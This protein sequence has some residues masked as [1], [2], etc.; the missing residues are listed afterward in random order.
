MSQKRFI[1]IH[2]FIQQ[3][4]ERVKITK[5]RKEDGGKRYEWEDEEGTRLKMGGEGGRE[6]MRRRG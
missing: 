6:E 5:G 3:A 1:F 4:A 2:S